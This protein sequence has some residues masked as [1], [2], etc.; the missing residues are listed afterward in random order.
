MEKKCKTENEKGRRR[1]RGLDLLSPRRPASLSARARGPAS[2]PSRPLTPA[3]PL[4][5]PA[6]AATLAPRVSRALP[7]RAL[8]SFARSRCQRNPTCQR[9]CASS[10]RPRRIPPPTERRQ[11]WQG[12]PG[13]HARGMDL[14][15]PW[16]HAHATPRDYRM[17][18]SAVIAFDPCPSITELHGRARL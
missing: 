8:I 13:G 4:A 2:R 3:H 17:Q 7:T 10:P 14:S 16:R 5:P 9:Y 6:V 12:G 11:R 18:A 15:P 1:P